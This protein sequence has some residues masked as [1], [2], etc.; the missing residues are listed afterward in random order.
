METNHCLNS[1]TVNKSHLSS[2]NKYQWHQFCSLYFTCS[3]L[4]IVSSIIA[5]A[6]FTHVL[7]VLL[8][9]VPIQ[10]LLSPLKAESPIPQSMAL[11]WMI[12][13]WICLDELKWNESKHVRDVMDSLLS[14][15]KE[16]YKDIP[17]ALYLSASHSYVICYDWHE[18]LIIRWVIDTVVRQY[19]LCSIHDHIPLF[20]PC[21]I[22][23]SNVISPHKRWIKYM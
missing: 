6:I 13:L 21:F 1:L 5:H 20:S 16:I 2:L 23:G 3:L 10:C 8:H 9:E 19:G 11:L 4:F 15:I 18:E 22:F 17:F 12:F 7:T 14:H